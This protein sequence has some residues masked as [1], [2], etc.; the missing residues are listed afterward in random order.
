MIVHFPSFHVEIRIGSIAISII[1]EKHSLLLYTILV[2][3]NITIQYPPFKIFEFLPFTMLVNFEETIREVTYFYFYFSRSSPA[4]W[5]PILEICE[6]SQLKNMPLGGRSLET[7][8]IVGS[9][10]YCLKVKTNMHF[11]SISFYSSVTLF[12]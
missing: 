7:V 1:I 4:N 11:I 8:A 5:P 6:G 2:Q 9:I 3:N 12:Y 10:S